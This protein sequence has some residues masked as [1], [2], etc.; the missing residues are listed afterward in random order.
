MF[1]IQIKLITFFLL[2][3]FSL[4]SELRSRTGSLRLSDWLNRP[5]VLETND[6]YDSLARG[7]ATQPEQ[8]ADINFD[9]EVSDEKYNSHNHHYDFRIIYH[10]IIF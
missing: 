7:L 5:A 4:I 6:N 1:T 10:T 8:L 9:P 2:L 3:Y